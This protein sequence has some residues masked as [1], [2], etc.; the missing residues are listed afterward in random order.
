MTLYKN[1]YWIIYLIFLTSCARQSSPTGGPKDTIPPIL[2]RASP[3]DE[4]IN[5]DA[6][7]LEL[8]FSEDVILNSPKEQLIVTP[9]IGKDY[10]IRARKNVVVLK[11]AE[12][13]L[14]STT[15]T[16]NFRE[17]VQDITEKNPV[18]NLSLAYS[19]G[20]YLDSLSISGTVYDLLKGKEIPD[21]TVALHVRNDTFNILQHPATYF[22][23][24]N[25]QGRFQIDHLKP[26]AYFVYAFQDKNRNIIVNS[27]TEAYGFI[28]EHQQLTTNIDSVNIGVINLD[29]GPLKMTSARPY[30][31]YFNIR[32]TKNLRTFKLTA[33][34][35]SNIVYSFGEDQANIKLYDT[36]EKDSIKVHLLALDSIDNVIDTTLHAKFLTREVTPEKFQMSIT[37]TSLIGYKGEL[38]A[39]IQF[40]KPIVNILFDSIYFQVDSLTRVNVKSENFTWAELTRELTLNLPID[41]AL[42]STGE[43]NG[44][45]RRPR[46]QSSTPP[47]QDTSPIKI[48]ELNLRKSAFISV[49]RDSS[50]ATVQNIR[51]LAEQDLSI[52]NVGIMTDEESFIVQLLDN[53]H[54]VVR[55]VRN[56]QRVRFTDVIPGDYQMRLIIDLNQN[57]R[58]DPGN[59]FQNQ[60]P[61]PVVYYRAA[62][63][64]TAIKGVKENWEIGTNDEM[65]ITY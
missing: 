27:R 45:G 30:N 6:N 44:N 54:K 47:R 34:D 43:E 50:E 15:Y 12:P 31:T 57:G 7:Q 29:A 18:R 63:G 41:P 32:T 55:Q 24:T 61:E 51:P 23:K 37:K 4:T 25:K 11:F 14:D 22:T 60:E 26:D 8:L 59:Y 48:N 10:E 65:L 16:F 64:T 28:P 3:P 5:F 9:T 13:L 46:A 35:S 2:V 38:T 53:N 42:F 58:W 52:I 62:D 39:T 20:N 33:T 49:E 21:A 17:T 1:L 36:T 56:Q 19:T 40:T